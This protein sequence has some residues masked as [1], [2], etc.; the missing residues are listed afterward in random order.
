MELVRSFIAIELPPEFRAELGVLEEKLKAARHSFVKWVDPE[1]IH[2]TLKFLG[3]VPADAIPRIVE[4]TSRAAQSIPP[5]S[6]LMGGP[7]AFP[8]WLRPQVLW[9]GIA[10]ETGRLADLH[11]ELDG[12]LS[13]LGYPPESRAFS[14]HL[15]LGR[16]RDRASA[17]ER[18]SLGQWAQSVR[19]ES[20]LTFEVDGVRLMKSHLTPAGP[21]YSQLAFA[22]LRRPG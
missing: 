15:T 11:R 20:R 14:P 9:V 16:L 19:F 12:A 21:V 3:G 8:N 10:G 1:T 4:A 7:G 18:R 22:G 13:P 6:L 17:E 5:F 2:L